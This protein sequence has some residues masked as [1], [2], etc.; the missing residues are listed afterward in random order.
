ME[1]RKTKDGGRE[2]KRG[3]HA[4]RSVT[5]QEE[6]EQ[7]LEGSRSATKHTNRFLQQPNTP[8]HHTG[9][10]TDSRNILLYQRNVASLRLPSIS[11][12]TLG[13]ERVGKKGN[14]TFDQVA[15]CDR[16]INGWEDGDGGVGWEAS[17]RS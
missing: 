4:S 3:I 14:L 8:S 12:T 17:E 5:E 16:K 9:S 13:N 6:P 7:Q 15:E 11:M 1:E 2:F 10:T